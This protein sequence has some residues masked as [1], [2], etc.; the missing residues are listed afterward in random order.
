MSH[1]HCTAH[2]CYIIWRFL[3]LAVFTVFL[4]RFIFNPSANTEEHLSMFKFLGILF[5]VAMRTKKPLDLHLASIVW[6]QLCGMPLTSDDLEE[7]DLLFMQ[8]LRG[9]KEIDK[10]GVTEDNFH[11][12][13]IFMDSIWSS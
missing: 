8:T 2:E 6:K 7:V 9:I 4:Y 1:A 11:E 3:S 5:G 13:T 12:V 10:S